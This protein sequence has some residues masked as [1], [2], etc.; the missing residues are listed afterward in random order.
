MKYFDKL[1]E[2]VTRAFEARAVDTQKLK[3]CVK[4]DLDADGCYY[5]V[6]I[7]F[8]EQKL[9][10]LSGYDRLITKSRKTQGGFDFKDFS[11]IPVSD[12]KRLYVEHLQYTSRLIA[13]HENGDERCIARF[14]GGFGEKFEQFCRRFDC[15]KKNETPDDSALEDKN[16]FCPVCGE[17]YPD[18]NRRF[19][20][21]CTKRSW[22]FKRL[23][24]LFG[25]YKLQI[26]IIL[27]LIAVA[28]AMEIISPYFGSKLLYDEVLN[29][30][31][32][33]YGEVLFVILCMASFSLFGVLFRMLNGIIVSIVTP[34]VIHKLRVDI[35][36]S[37]QRLSLSFFTNKQTGSLMSRVDNDSNDVY[38]FIVDV[39][40][41]F[42]SNIAKVAGLVILMLT[43]NP[44]LSFSMFAV[45]AIVL[46]IEF[47]W[48]RGQRRMWR[49]RDIARRGVNS[50]LSDAMNG[51][52]VV[53]AFA[54]EGQ[55]I[56]RFASKNNALYR[57]EYE[58][59][60]RSADFFPLQQGLYGILNGLIYCLGAYFVLDGKLQFGGLTL[61]VSYFNIILEPMYFFMYVGNDWARCTDAA[62]RMFEI[63][64]SEPEVKPPKEPAEIP[65]GLLKG[66][67]EFKNVTFEY[68]AGRPVL[69]NMS[70]K[71]ESGKFTGIVGKTGAGK[72]TIIN[73]ISRMYDVTSGEIT[74][75]G[76]PIKKIPFDVL[77]RSIGVVSQET[78]LFMGTIADNIRYARP[79][80]TMEEVIAAAKSANA[81]EFIAKL[82]NGYNT[83]TGSGGVSLSGGE[84]QRISI[85]RA[86][87]QKPNILIL[88]EAT[89][90]MDTATERKIQNAIDSLKQGRT[91]IAI[92]HRLSTLRDADTLCVIDH[93]E[94]CES[95]THDELIRKRDGKY[96]ELYKL[97][98]NA[99][100]SV[101]IE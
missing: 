94:V 21:Y 28:V 39:I 97:Q 63:L 34:K 40:P 11:E 77:R 4:A 58:R 90:A 23:L 59:D 12:V 98:S 89:A 64:D 54:R 44:I 19:C 99:L 73:L 66:D 69:K 43:I 71:S 27:A 86:L 32:K 65:D 82:P 14:S 88:D 67:I 92:A 38:Y 7:T 24:G 57:A 55:E 70:F 62:G 95:G 42:I 91:I 84:K 81:H 48:F 93:G 22:V 68:Q 51:H 31:G 35:F 13:E 25:D 83:V 72:S 37:M 20:P 46:V 10:L 101:G 52:R 49:N 96:A 47:A 15:L 100:K 53:K 26:L 17:K 30:K 33:L 5:D 61:L 2:P 75:D 36:S 16:L 74:I 18:P 87:I 80:A 56:N 8:D 76:V 50:V 85:A 6:Y 45:V 78:Y 3:Y 79:E 9:Y 60:K 29:E 41:Q 1:T